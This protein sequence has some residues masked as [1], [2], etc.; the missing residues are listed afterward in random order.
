MLKVALSLAFSEGEGRL[1]PPPVK[2]GP[3]DQI[4]DPLLLPRHKSLLSHPL[5][6]FRRTTDGQTHN[7]CFHWTRE[8][9]FRIHNCVS[10]CHQGGREICISMEATSAVVSCVY[11]D[12]ITR[13]AG[14]S[15]EIKM[16]IRI[17]LSRINSLFK[18]SHHD[19]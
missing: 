7:V 19:N 18:F 13:A 5:V 10:A 6:I 3:P 11:C 14:G 16:F 15:F 2:V 12:E 17:H 8:F 9:P 4:P 1:T